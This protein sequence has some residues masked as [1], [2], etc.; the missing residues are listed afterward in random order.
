MS[1]GT[2]FN[3][4]VKRNTIIKH[5]LLNC[6]G[7]PEDSNPPLER[8]V[9]AVEKL[10]SIFAEES[11]WGVDQNVHLWAMSNKALFLAAG[12][13]I[14]DTTGDLPADVIS[15]EAATFRSVNGDDV[16]LD[17]IPHNTYAGLSPKNEI[18]DPKFLYWKEGADP[19]NHKFFIWP[20]KSSVTA[21]NEVT[22]S[23]VNYKCILKH[24]S[25][26]VN[27]PGVGSDWT[28]FWQVGGSSGSA[29]VTAT[30]YT[31]GELLAITYKRPLFLF[32]SPYENP[33]MPLGWDNYLEYRLALALSPHY[34]LELDERKWLEQATAQARHRLFPNSRK[35][36]DNFH[37]KALFF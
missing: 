16:A 17:L 5:A 29:W 15:L 32:A 35:K 13:Y 12:K 3:S 20:T 31:S 4:P 18:G 6:H 7:W 9:Q 28:L 11:Q 27:Q 24:T 21:P 14:F 23:S 26:S 36:E 2:I 22:V 25:A 33:D 8:V 10:N 19:A 30:S 1:V 37:N 34:K